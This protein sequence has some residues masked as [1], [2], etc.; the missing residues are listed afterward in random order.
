V[1]RSSISR[2]LASLGTS[3][4]AGS[5]AIEKGC[6]RGALFTR[7]GGVWRCASRESVALPSLDI[8]KPPAATAGA[9][10][11]GALKQLFPDGGKRF[12][13]LQVAV[14]DPLGHLDTLELDSI[15]K[16][17]QAC[18]DLVRWHFEKDAHLDPSHYEFDCQD[19]GREGGKV[20]LL[21]QALDSRWLGVVRGALTEAGLDGY[22]L[23]MS[24]C[25]RFNAHEEVFRS[26]TE[27]LALVSLTVDSWSLGFRDPQGRIRFLRSRW[28][29]DSA[30]FL[31]SVGSEIENAIRAYS[32]PAR[33]FPVAQV[34]V[35]G[36]VEDCRQLAEVL[37]PRLSRPCRVLP[38]A[39]DKE[40]D[41]PAP[42]G[43][44]ELFSFM[45]RAA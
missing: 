30:D 32:M 6:V 7:K 19:L 2:S 8:E 44:D 24:F 17:R 37:N 26:T 35:T 16:A 12:L 1:S 42:V 33:N 13:P 10:L 21:G 41:L 23:N 34:A 3:Y 11:V 18:R 22:T 29:R 27:G 38:A 40:T 31:A 4:E 20:L 14:P 25:Q 45:T 43:M 9:D 28:R 39:G 5:L 15:P 36:E